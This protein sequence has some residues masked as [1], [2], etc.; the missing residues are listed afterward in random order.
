MSGYMLGA[1]GPRGLRASGPPQPPR[2][3]TATGLPHSGEYATSR[4]QVS[5]RY[6][7]IASRPLIH[8][9]WRRCRFGNRVPVEIALT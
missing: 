8:G 6:E 5:N 9:H 7:S 4:W 1:S 3:Q 2:P